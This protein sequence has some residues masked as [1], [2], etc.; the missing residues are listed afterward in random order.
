MP[1]IRLFFALQLNEEILEDLEAVQSDLRPT[2][3]RLARRDQIHLTLSFLGDVEED[4]LQSLDLVVRKP[5]THAFPLRLQVRG[6]SRFKSMHGTRV[7]YAKVKDREGDLAEL[8]DNLAYACRHYFE[9][10]ET[11]KFRPHITL[12]RN[13]VSSRSDEAMI[14]KVLS[15]WREFP[16]GEWTPNEMVLFRSDNVEGRRTY[17]AIKAYR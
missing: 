9:K 5:V 4:R 15:R 8:Q 11:S 13:R 14:S 10:Q 17:T 7:I 6:L 2:G 12:A 3:L 16:F 1:H